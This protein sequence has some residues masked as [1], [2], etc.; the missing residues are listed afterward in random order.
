MT[1]KFAGRADAFDGF[2]VNNK[3]VKGLD[4][5]LPGY[6]SPS[7][8]SSKKIN[9]S[10]QAL[11]MLAS[12][13]EYDQ[14]QVIKEMYYVSAN[15]HSRSV[16]RHK[17]F[18]LIRIYRSRYPFKNYHYLLTI[19]LKDGEVVIHDIAFD[20]RLHGRDIA[21]NSHQ[22]TQMYH[23]KKEDGATGKYNGTQNNQEV[24]ALMEEWNA[25]KAQQ[26]SNVRTI[27]VTVNGMLND[28]NKAAGLMGIHTQVAY[29]EDNPREYTLFHNPTDEW[30][31]DI[32]ECGFD[33]TWKTSHNAKHLAAVMKQC[34]QNGQKVKWTVHSQGAIIFASALTYLEG[35]N[36]GLKLPNQ[37]LVVHAGGTGVAKL[38]RIAK[39][40]GLRINN[41]KT[42]INPFDAVP[43]VC[44]FEMKNS[45]SSLM[46][47][48]K[49]FGL[50]INDDDM[51]ISPHTLP[52][53]GLELYRL[54]LINSGHHKAL[55][56]VNDVDLLIKKLNNTNRC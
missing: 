50:V 5:F 1:W 32:I 23:V 26:T 2:A 34:A 46:K 29:N 7:L 31:L 4:S 30:K 20:E 19:K 16:V 52:Y 36:P 39:K 28:Y 17:R 43:N 21:N 8:F 33:K 11:A 15:P 18:P 42:R 49:A 54:Q 12:M 13:N 41:H 47:C 37:E 51:T 25:S 6:I 24:K 56:R 22:R 27:H 55:K 10:R 44:G 40:V 48:M 35:I 45:N 9:M 3:T 38:D 14:M 53:F